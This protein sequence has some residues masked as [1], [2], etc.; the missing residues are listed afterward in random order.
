MLSGISPMMWLRSIPPP[1]IPPISRPWRRLHVQKRRVRDEESAIC[2]DEEAV[3]EAEAHGEEP[4]AK[5][6][7]RRV[8]PELEKTAPA[9]CKSQREQHAHT[10]PRR[11]P[12]NWR[13]RERGWD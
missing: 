1:P 3:A 8:S 6:Q 9:H 2:G 7:T 4:D 11:T 12:W 5:S 10:P 13:A